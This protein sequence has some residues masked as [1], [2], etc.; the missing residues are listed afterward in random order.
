MTVREQ[1]ETERDLKRME[2]DKKYDDEIRTISRCKSY[3]NEASADITDE[4]QL[5]LLKIRDEF[6]Q[7]VMDL[8]NVK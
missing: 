7:K 6:N 3:L 5:S 4:Y 8:P 1:L 2:L